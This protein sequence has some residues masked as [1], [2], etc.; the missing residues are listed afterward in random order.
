MLF[1]RNTTEPWDLWN[2]HTTSSLFTFIYKTILCIIFCKCHVNFCDSHQQ[3]DVD[4]SIIYMCLHSDH[5]FTCVYIWNPLTASFQYNKKW[6]K[7]K[8]RTK[9][10]KKNHVKVPLKKAYMYIRL[11]IKMPNEMRKKLMKSFN[12]DSA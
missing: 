12:F 1:C 8:N 6:K 5:E 10:K 11:L 3:A 4:F 7:N 9:P 2:C